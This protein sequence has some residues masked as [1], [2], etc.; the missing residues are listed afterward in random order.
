MLKEFLYSPQV[1]ISSRFVQTGGNPGEVVINLAKEEAANL[2]IMGSRG[3]GLIR[4]TIL[5]SVSDYIVHH[6]STPVIVVPPT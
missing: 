2:I 6:A 1:A 5:G 4:R 3:L